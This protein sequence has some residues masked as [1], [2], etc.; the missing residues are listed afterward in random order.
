MDDVYYTN[1][2]YMLHC[3][4]VRREEKGG[5]RA[6]RIISIRIEFSNGPGMNGRTKK[7]LRSI[8]TSKLETK[9]RPKAREAART[10]EMQWKTT[11]AGTLDRNHGGG[12]QERRQ[13][14]KRLCTPP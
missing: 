2:T 11:D 14:L 6:D 9:T 4:Q 13:G 10:G 8:T 5:L 1:A 12:E 3:S 7:I